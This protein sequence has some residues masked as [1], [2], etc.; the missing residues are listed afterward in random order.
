MLLLQKCRDFHGVRNSLGC[1]KSSKLQNDVE[2][3]TGSRTV[4]TNDSNKKKCKFDRCQWSHRAHLERR[5]LS[6]FLGAQESSIHAIVCVCVC[7]VVYIGLVVPQ[8]R[9]PST[10]ML[11]QRLPFKNLCC[12]FHAM[13]QDVASA[14]H[15]DLSIGHQTWQWNIGHLF[16]SIFHVFSCYFSEH[17]LASHV[18][19]LIQA[20]HCALTGIIVS[21]EN[22]PNLAELFRNHI[23][24]PE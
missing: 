18:S 2:Q 3:S 12:N 8:A 10:W 6:N 24:Y 9:I 4:L 21:K 13:L 20:P 15:H 11:S 22:D 17:F 7:P 1:P 5:K 19:G 23:I 14:P 16:P